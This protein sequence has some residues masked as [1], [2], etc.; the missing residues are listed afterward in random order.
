MLPSVPSTT[1]IFFTILATILAYS[2]FI[3]G[4]P[5]PSRIG[6]LTSDVEDTQDARLLLIVLLCLFCLR[7]IIGRYR[8]DS[9]PLPV[10]QPSVPSHELYAVSSTGPNLQ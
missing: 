2:I 10:T 6:Q 5:L 8:E 7:L 1:P 9:P 3:N 4:L